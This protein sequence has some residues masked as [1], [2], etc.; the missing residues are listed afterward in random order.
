MHYSKE[1]PKDIIYLM[2]LFG[3]S[4]ILQMIDKD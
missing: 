4:L 3:V 2:Q 1:T